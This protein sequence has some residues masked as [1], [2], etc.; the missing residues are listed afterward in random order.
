[1]QIFALFPFTFVSNDDSFPF[2]V[3]KILNRISRDLFNPIKRGD[4]K[5]NESRLRNLNSPQNGFV[6]LNLWLPGPTAKG[7]VFYK[8]IM[9]CRLLH[10]IIL[11]AEEVNTFISRKITLTAL[12]PTR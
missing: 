9:C 8:V 1:M 2:L 12:S 6:L 3:P 5:W 4:Q 11:S 10:L 7:T